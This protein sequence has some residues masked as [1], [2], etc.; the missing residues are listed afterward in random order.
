MA[1]LPVCMSVPYSTEAEQ[2][3]DWKVCAHRGYAAVAVGNDYT[4]RREP[5]HALG[6]SKAKP[7]RM[8][9]VML[10]DKC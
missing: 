3:G 8:D 2:N 7:A 9:P 6:R 10:F 5:K 4:L 1:C